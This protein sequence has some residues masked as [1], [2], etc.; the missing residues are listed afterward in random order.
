MDAND[1]QE[2]AEAKP[3][4]ILSLLNSWKTKKQLQLINY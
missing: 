1:V 3:S 4:Y 2:K